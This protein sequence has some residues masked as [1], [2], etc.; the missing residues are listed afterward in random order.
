MVKKGTN[1]WF[2]AEKQDNTSKKGDKLMKK[3]KKNGPLE[4]A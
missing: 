1:L 3:Q 4:L 2:W